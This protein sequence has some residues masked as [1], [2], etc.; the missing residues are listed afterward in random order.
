MIVFLKI[1]A[2]IFLFVT[3]LW[4]TEGLLFS[5]CYWWKTRKPLKVYLFAF[6]RFV[7]E[8]RAH[9]YYAAWT[10]VLLYLMNGLQIND[11]MKYVY[12]VAAFIGSFAIINPHHVKR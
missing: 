8:N 5:I 10:I 1:A 12:A 2:A 11:P 7:I 9:I 3:A 6:L 4:I